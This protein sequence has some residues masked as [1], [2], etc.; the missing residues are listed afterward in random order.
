MT[1]HADATVTSADVSVSLGLIVTEL[2]INCL[3]HAFP[4]RPAGGTIAV[5]YRL[6]ADGWTLKVSDNGLGIARGMDPANAG[7]GTGIVNALA[8]KLQ[9]KVS[10]SDNHPGTTVTVVHT[11][12]LDAPGSFDTEQATV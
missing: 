10:I 7:L 9:A 1:V 3:K 6:S 12:P 2:V 11:A 8:G 4:E 5:D